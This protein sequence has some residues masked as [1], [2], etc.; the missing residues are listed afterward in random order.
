MQAE[1]RLRTRCGGGVQSLPG[2]R[3]M[4]SGLP[5]AQWNSG[6]VTDPAQF[7]LAAVRTWYAGRAGGA[8]VPWGMRVAAGAPFAFGRCLFRKRCMALSADQ[9]R[10]PQWLDPPRRAEVRIRAAAPDDLDAVVAIDTAAFGDTPAQVRGWI[11]PHLSAADIAVA[12]AEH[13]DMPV[14]IATA[15]HTRDRAGPCVGLYGIA[16]EAHWRR[17]GIA[18]ALTAHLLER[19]F[20][21]GSALAHLNPDDDAAAAVYARLGFVETAGMDV[22]VDL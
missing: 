7:D 17:R 1:G 4:A 22:Y 19:A 9:W 10:P 3:L 20:A 15:I 16:V 5:H 8:G 2:V 13:D 11:G 14:G 21:A 18:S 6:D 12:I